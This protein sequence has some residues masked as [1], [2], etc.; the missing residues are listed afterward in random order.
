MRSVLIGIGM[1]FGTTVVSWAGGPAFVAGSGYNPGVI[2]QPMIWANGSIQYF[3]DQG[4]LSPI[5]PG[6]QADAFVATAFGVW[7]GVSGVALTVSRAGRLAEDVNGSNR[8]P[9]VRAHAGAL[10]HHLAQILVLGERR[11]AG[12]PLSGPHERRH[13]TLEAKPHGSGIQAPLGR[14]FPSQRRN[15]CPHGH[16]TGALVRVRPPIHEQNFVPEVYR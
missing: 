9:R 2:G 5:L 7:T 12:T 8:L 15:V 10:G 6:A 4:D 16:Q 13:Q 14:L 3:T 11:R 1:V